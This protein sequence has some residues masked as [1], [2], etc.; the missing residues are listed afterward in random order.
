MELKF[1]GVTGLKADDLKRAWTERHQRG[2]SGEG[3]TKTLLTALL[4]NINHNVS[5]KSILLHLLCS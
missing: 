3:V 1:L 5:I 2:G 4:S